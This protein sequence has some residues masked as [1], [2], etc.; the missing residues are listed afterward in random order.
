MIIY[1]NIDYNK[2]KMKVYCDGSCLDNGKKTSQGGIGVFFGVNDPRNVSEKLICNKVTNQVAE[3]MA[4]QKALEILIKSDHK[5]IVYIYSDS[6]YAVQI[7]TAWIHDWEK[8]GWKRKTGNIEN[9]ELIKDIYTKAKKVTVIF[10]HCRSH[11]RE[12]LQDSPEYEVWF[13]NNQADKLATNC[14]FI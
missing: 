4:I 6:R 11:Q 14:Y 1:R 5:G 12:P 9:L 2:H 8:N 3:L 13:G 7:F 10:K